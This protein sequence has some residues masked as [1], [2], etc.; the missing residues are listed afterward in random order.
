MRQLPYAENHAAGGHL[1]FTDHQIR[2]VKPNEA[3]PQLRSLKV[4]CSL[5]AS[6]EYRDWW[7]TLDKSCA[8]CLSRA[9]LPGPAPPSQRR[10]ASALVLL[11]CGHPATAAATTPA[12]AVCTGPPLSQLRSR[13]IPPRKRGAQLGNW[14]GD[15]RQFQC[16]PQAIRAVRLDPKS[17]QFSYLWALPLRVREFEDAVAPLQRSIAVDPSALKPHLLFA[18]I[19]V[20]LN[21]PPDAAQQCERRSRS[22]PPTGMAIH[23]LSHSLIPQSGPTKSVCCTMQGSTRILPSILPSL[24]RGPAAVTMPS[25]RSTAA[26]K[27]SPGSMPLSN[28]LVTVYMKVSRRAIRRARCEKTYYEANLAITLS[29]VSYMRALVYNGDWGPARPVG[30]KLLAEDAAFLSTLCTPSDYRAPGRRFCRG[31]R[32]PQSGSGPQSFPRQ[33]ALQPRGHALSPPRLSWRRHAAPAGQCPRRQRSPKSI[34]SSPA[35]SV[36]T[37]RP[38]RRKRK[39]SR[40]NRQ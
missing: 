20:R 17:A 26:L 24:I 29:Q 35:H 27:A 18:S 37:G 32:S 2:I 34:S 40:T 14:F 10:H 11:A 9:I 5:R 16:A 30:R 33:S 8:P 4:P 31:P 1:H 28:A 25:A 36:P 39:Y 38:T 15:Q 12:H 23:S 21:Q 19:Y 7:S 3:I 13:P 22:T 6:V